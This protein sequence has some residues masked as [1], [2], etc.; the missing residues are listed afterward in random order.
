MRFFFYLQKATGTEGDRNERLTQGLDAVH[1]S[2][3]PVK[4]AIP[5]IVSSLPPTQRTQVDAG[6]SLL[7]E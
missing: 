7:E 3:Y 4:V 5:G 6:V 2:G 1:G